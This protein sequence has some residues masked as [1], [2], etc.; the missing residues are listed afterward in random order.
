MIMGN[1]RFYEKS[2]I[3]TYLTVLDDEWY[4]GPAQ[5]FVDYLMS[6][7]VCGYE[8][9]IAALWIFGQDTAKPQK[10]YADR[11]VLQ[12]ELLKNV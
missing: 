1:N 7:Q 5:E 9:W 12:Q 2:L 10:L 6:V 8:M 11:K 4:V 3:I